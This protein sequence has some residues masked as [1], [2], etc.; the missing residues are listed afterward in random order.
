MSTE[1]DLRDQIE[2]S[3]GEGPDLPPTRDLLVR[4]RRA[5]RR[6]RV[7]EAGSV[8]AVAVVA[9]SGFAL[10]GGGTDRVAPHP[11]GPAASGTPTPGPTK[12]AN[13]EP[14]TPALPRIVE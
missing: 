11:V 12:A 10:V 9:V 4:G 5:L 3:F 2:R 1:T 7:A 6:R 13:P 8:L 14:A